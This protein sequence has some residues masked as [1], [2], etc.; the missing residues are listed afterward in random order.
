MKL[1]RV[2]Q[3]ILISLGISLFSYFSPAVFAN[4]PSLLETLYQEI[5]N[6][7]QDLE[8]QR[9]LARTA[10]YTQGITDIN[11]ELKDYYYY[12]DYIREILSGKNPKWVKDLPDLRKVLSVISE[13]Y[14]KKQAESRLAEEV[15]DGLQEKKKR[16]KPSEQI[17]GEQKRLVQR[18]HEELQGLSGQKTAL[19][20]LEAIV[21]KEL[22]S[23]PNLTIAEIIAKHQDGLAIDLIDDINQKGIKIPNFTRIWNAMSRIYKGLSK[24]VEGGIDLVRLKE[25]MI[26]TA[27]RAGPI[28]KNLIRGLLRDLPYFIPIEVAEI[29]EG[30]SQRVISLGELY[31]RR[32]SLERALD[33]FEG[34]E[35]QSGLRVTPTENPEV[36]N[37]SPEEA[38]ELKKRHFSLLN[39]L[40]LVEKAIKEAEKNLT[41]WDK[42]FYGVKPSSDNQQG[43]ATPYAPRADSNLPYQSLPPQ[44]LVFLNWFH[45][46]IFR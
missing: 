42:L 28:A 3:V 21:S 1:D 20:R 33:Y 38:E 9:E 46:L 2:C 10:G 25:I 5:N 18:L 45:S 23:N 27:K 39:Q 36:F 35:T 11:K 8:R 31:A 37:I 30:S 43:Q 12:R 41:F 15:L 17:V 7:V 4:E 24:S 29:A 14:T 34:F 13:E 40:R 32:E 19:T 16:L 6:R 44:P 26:N 22:A